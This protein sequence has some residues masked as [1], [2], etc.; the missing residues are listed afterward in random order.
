MQGSNFLPHIFFRHSES[1][2]QLH[3]TLFKEVEVFYNLH[4]NKQLF[5][6]LLHPRLSYQTSVI[7]FRLKEDILE[8]VNKNIEPDYSSYRNE[9]DTGGIYS[10]KDITAMGGHIR[11]LRTLKRANIKLFEKVFEEDVKWQ[12]IVDMSQYA[13]GNSFLLMLK[14][15]W[16]W[17]MERGLHIMGINAP[18]IN[19][20][21]LL[22]ISSPVAKALRFLFGADVQS[23]LRSTYVIQQIAQ[24][25]RNDGMTGL[26]SNVDAM[27]VNS[28]LWVIGQNL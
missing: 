18:H 15:Y 27:W 3:Q 10:V 11:S 22:P 8:A 7:Y 1:V 14:Y 21:G 16:V 25:L 19:Y 13:V 5:T 17:K 20:T 2:F 6:L 23:L 9:D 28:A 4:S 24:E 12:D 26:G